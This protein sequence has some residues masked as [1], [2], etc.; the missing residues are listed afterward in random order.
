[1]PMVIRVERD[2]KT[3]Q[4]AAN[5]DSKEAFN[6][7]LTFGLFAAAAV[8]AFAAIASIFIY[9]IQS[10]EMRKQREIMQVTLKRM[11]TQTAIQGETLRPRLSISGFS[12]NVFQEAINGERV[13]IA[14]RISNSGGIPAYGVI[15]ETWVEFLARG[16]IDNPFQFSSDA[17]HKTSLP[18]NVDTGTPQAFEIPL[19]RSLSSTEIQAMHKAEGTLCF[20]MRLTYDAFGIERHFDHAYAVQPTAMI[21]ISKYTSAD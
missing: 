5:E 4:E 2:P 17:E 12:N 7:R 3:P 16:P 11:E 18:I 1:M 21:S 6:K 15:T 10:R 9:W 19:N 20:R 13:S 8:Q 14:L